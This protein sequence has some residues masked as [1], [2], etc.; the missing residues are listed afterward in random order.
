MQHFSKQN[1]TLW[2][3][4][5][6]KGKH[7]MRN[8]IAAF[9]VGGGICVL[10]E[11]LRVL[12]LSFAMSDKNAALAATISLIFL[13]ALLT[14]LGVFDRIA[15]FAGAGTLVP[16]TGFAN[17]VVSPAM[18]NKSEGL[19]LGVGAKIFTVAGPVILF[20]VLSGA[21]YGLIYAL[22]LALGGGV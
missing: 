11:G 21:L 10:G 6:A 22:C 7:H 2:A 1:Y 18:D 5:Y 13:S 17:A 16:V 12:F 4:E 3:D 9:F 14:A 19:V 8:A 15:R 20:G